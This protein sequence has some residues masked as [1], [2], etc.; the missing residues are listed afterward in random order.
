MYSCSVALCSTRRIGPRGI[1]CIACRST[2]GPIS[3]RMF[4]RATEPIFSS[5]GC[6]APMDNVASTA[7]V[8][9]MLRA[10]NAHYFYVIRH[11]Q[12]LVM[13]TVNQVWHNLNMFLQKQHDL[14]LI[15]VVSSEKAKSDFVF[16]RKNSLAVR[17]S[18]YSIRKVAA[19][20]HVAL[21]ECKAPI[22]FGSLC[23]AYLIDDRPAC[24]WA[25]VIYLKIALL[26]NLKKTTVAS[27]GQY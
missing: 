2:V 20:R 12:L 21:F 10:R 7:W 22:F 13:D 18:D 8:K 9:N 16:K 23:R 1:V 11:F 5:L 26:L 6:D 19:R 14:Y 17:W 24:S 25:Y 27:S 15:E 3:N 4:T